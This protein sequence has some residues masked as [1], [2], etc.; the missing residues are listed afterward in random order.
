MDHY[1]TLGV[2]RTSTPDEIKKA[3]RKLAGKHHPDKGGNE[4]D[5]KRVQEAYEVLSDPQKKQQY[6]NPNPFEGMQGNPFGD[7]FGDIFGQSFRN[8]QRANPD[9]MVNVEVE[10][11]AAYT[12]TTFHMDLPSGETVA[13]RVPAG[14]RDGARLRVA[15]KGRQRDPNLP[16]G[17]LYVNVHVRMPEDWG[18]DGDDLYVRCRIDALDAI[19]GTEIQFKHI[20]NKTYSAKIPAG[21]QP[22]EKVRLNGLGMANPRS[23][24][25]GS[26]Y[27]IIEVSIPDITDQDTLD[28]LNSIKQ[29]GSN[30]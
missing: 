22:G 16:P 20:N 21:I 18:R 19:T 5:F 30:G 2:S 4:A 28:I 25:D 11:D 10:L 27:L 6:D 12:G 24:R 26:L 15:G 29:R 9:S 14:I 23:G 3:Y 17:D 8:Q 1:Q 7:I 13:V